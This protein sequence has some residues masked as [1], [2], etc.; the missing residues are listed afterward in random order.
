MSEETQRIVWLTGG[1]TGIGAGLCA[2]LLDAGATVVSFARRKPDIDSPRLHNVAVDLTDAEATRAAIA[3]VAKEFPATEVVHNAG[4]TFER[5]LEEVSMADFDSA[6]QLHLASAISLVQAALPSMRA[7]NY[8]RIVLMS[9]R[10]VVGLEKRTV[11]SATKAGMIG[12]ARTWA[13]ELASAGITVNVVAPGPI[14][15]TEMFHDVV[16]KGSELIERVADR[17][18]VGRLGR[19]SDVARAVEFFLSS[20]AGFV[21]GQ[22]LF[23][24]GGSSVGNMSFT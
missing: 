14:E 24:C 12:M 8:G 16:P 3:E 15:D 23:V 21:T 10:A 18:P 2:R 9:T 19:P 22:T 1:S 4:A 20:D 13:L 17:V 7:A 6:A 5:P 11:Y